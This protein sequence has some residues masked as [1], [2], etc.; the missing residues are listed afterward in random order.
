[1]GLLPLDLKDWTEPDAHLA[2]DLAEKERLLAERYDEVVDIR[3]E[4]RARLTRS[5]R[6]AG[7][8]P[9]GPLPKLIPAQ[10]ETNCGMR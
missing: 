1:M 5:P 10:R 6:S 9:A 7:R 8:A 2:A 3:P 4:G